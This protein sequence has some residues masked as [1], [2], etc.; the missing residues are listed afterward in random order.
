MKIVAGNETVPFSSSWL[1]FLKLCALNR[2]QPDFLFERIACD[3]QLS[4]YRGYPYWLSHSFN[5][6]LLAD[7]TGLPGN[8]LRTFFIDTFIGNSHASGKVSIRHCPKCIAEGYHCVFFQLAFLTSCPL[9]NC[10]LGEC[11]VCTQALESPG[12][13][14]FSN[15]EDFF[16][17]SLPCRHFSFTTRPHLSL[18][19]AESFSAAERLKSFQGF[20]RWLRAATEPVRPFC[21]Y[22]SIIKWA[23]EAIKEK[24]TWKDGPIR[25]FE[26]KML[27][28]ANSGISPA[29]ALGPELSYIIIHPFNSEVD[30][31]RASVSPERLFAIVRRYIYKRY[32]R[33]HKK[34]YSYLCSLP[35]RGL[36]TLDAE[37]ACSVCSAFLAW[38]LSIKYRFGGTSGPNFASVVW[39]HLPHGSRQVMELWVAQFYTLLAGIERGLQITLKMYD[40]ISV[41]MSSNDA[42]L[43]IGDDAR[44]F[45]DSENPYSAAVTAVFSNPDLNISSGT[46]RCARRTRLSYMVNHHSLETVDFWAYR[47]RPDVLIKFW[48]GAHQK[49]GG[50]V[51]P[52]WAG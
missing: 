19:M 37:H 14:C 39:N 49:V 1:F 33:A 29:Q 30:E 36:H 10:L 38:E 31:G 7:S 18:S 5:L 47:Y 12:S 45:Y 43:R 40:R 44:I 2:S 6:R 26:S 9:H 41:E 52:I 50:Y 34:C 51:T 3:T 16:E 20:S 21:F 15:S 24:C 4:N 27:E 46:D 11:N 35:E 32:I 22:F 42:P 48:V 17:A 8:L 25:R 23:D 28:F 13:L